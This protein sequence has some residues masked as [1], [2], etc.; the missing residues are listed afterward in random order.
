MTTSTEMA[1]E[2]E[3]WPAQINHRMGTGDSRKMSYYWQ[4]DYASDVEDAHLWATIEPID[5][6]VTVSVGTVLARVDIYT[7]YETGELTVYVDDEEVCTVEA[8]G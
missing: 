4:L 5:N 1:S 2:P 7:N 6:E 3:N 8:E